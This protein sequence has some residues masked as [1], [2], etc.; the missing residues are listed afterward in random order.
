MHTHGFN[1]M[2]FDDYQS[3]LCLK[4]NEAKFNWLRPPKSVPFQVSV[5]LVTGNSIF[6][7]AE[8]KTFQ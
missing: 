6:L 1:T 4:L 7:S 3:F 5:I 2:I 8:D